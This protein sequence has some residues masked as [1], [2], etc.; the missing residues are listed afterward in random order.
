MKSLISQRSVSEHGSISR[1]AQPVRLYHQREHRE[2]VNSSHQTFVVRDLGTA[3]AT[4]ARHIQ[5]QIMNNFNSLN[6][7]EIQDLRL[8]VSRNLVT[9]K[10]LSNKD[11]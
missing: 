11:G 10:T 1:Q 2:Q 3:D 7:T 9:K 4:A 6:N 8:I 5:Y